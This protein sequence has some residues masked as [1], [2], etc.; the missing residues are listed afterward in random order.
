MTRFKRAR[1]LPLGMSVKA[2]TER[3]K[4]GRFTL[5]MDGTLP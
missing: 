1:E 5:K 4:K 2:F 3:L